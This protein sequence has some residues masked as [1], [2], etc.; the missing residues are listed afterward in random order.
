[1]NQNPYAI[2]FGRI[3]EQYINRD[4]IIDDI[5]QTLNNKIIQEQAF[6]LTG[7]RGTGKTVTLTA[8][9]RRIREDTDWI[10]VGLKSTGN[11]TEDL[12]ASLYHSVP[13]IRQFIDRQLNISILGFDVSLTQKAPD[14]SMDYALKSI[15]QEIKKQNKRVLVTIDEAHKTASLIDFIQ[16]FQ[17]LIREELP[18][19]I[20]ATGLYEDIESLE[21]TDGLTFFL[22]AKKY[23]MT[24]LNRGLIRAS[25][26]KTLGLTD[27]V[28]SEMAEITNGYAFAYQA[29]GKYMWD[30]KAKEVTDEVLIYFDAALSESVYNKIWSELTERDRYFLHFIVKKNPMPAAELLKLSGKRHNE[31]SEPRKRL[32]EKGIIDT[33]TRG[34]IS[35][36][37]PR[38][39]EFVENLE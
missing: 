6:K 5:I 39:K 12:V 26:K 24:P 36:C 35:L 14:A 28:S 20:I 10:V 1:M 11:I 27:E 23:E 19:F 33:T 7:I 25:Y 30:L 16:E 8:I 13:F 18:V 22:R 38:F 4:S 21:N 31:W 17:I 34:M 29:L 3:P 32:K 37:L 15:L 2:S 9:E